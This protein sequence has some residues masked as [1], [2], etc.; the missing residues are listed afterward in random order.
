MCIRDSTTVTRPV[1]IRRSS[2]RARIWPAR[3]NVDLSTGPPS[4][5]PIYKRALW[6]ASSEAHTP[7]T[8]YGSGS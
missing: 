5:G 2:Q 8:K 3:E 6:Q 1:K 4:H 7:D